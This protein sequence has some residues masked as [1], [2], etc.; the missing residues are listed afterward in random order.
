MLYARVANACKFCFSQES[1]FLTKIFLLYFSPTDVQV[2]LSRYG[3]SFGNGRPLPAMYRERV[4]DLYHNAFG[5][6]QI[7]REIRSSPRFVQK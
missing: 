4:L 7:A 2:R 6:R 1:V 3:G 5:H